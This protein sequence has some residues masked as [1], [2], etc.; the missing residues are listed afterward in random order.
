MPRATK[1][2]TQSDLIYT[3]EELMVASILFKDDPDTDQLL[4]F[5]DQETIDTEL[6]VDD[7][8]E[9]LEISALNWAEIA[10]RMSAYLSTGESMNVQSRAE[11]ECTQGHEKS[12]GPSAIKGS[13]D[14]SN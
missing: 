6:F 9:V 14:F 13:N 5:E 2:Q 11:S 1:I 3:A 10:E 8:S 7:T 12:H 4:L